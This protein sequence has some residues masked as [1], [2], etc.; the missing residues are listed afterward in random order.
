MDGKIYL[1]RNLTNNKVYI[2]QT[3]QPINER[4]KQ[5]KKLCQ[6]NKNQLIYKA[7]QKYGKD[8]FSIEEIE[9]GIKTYD[10]LNQK[11]AYYIERYNSM[12]PLGYNLSPG[13][14]LWRRRP[15]L[16]ENDEKVILELYSDGMSQRAIGERFN[17]G[18]GVIRKVLAK[19][20]IKARKRECNLPDRTSVIQEQDLY[21]MYVVDKMMIKDIAKHYGVDVRT[22]N[23]A[24]RRFNLE[25][26]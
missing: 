5:H 14:A 23:G 4:F 19:N 22:V 25:R 1:I 24:K 16:T 8:S 21:K 10:E 2:G 20:N 11:E 7:I 13:G 18:H 9:S 17:V 12:A 26:I 15:S 6:S 3:I